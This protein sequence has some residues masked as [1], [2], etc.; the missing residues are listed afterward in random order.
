MGSSEVKVQ[1]GGLKPMY[2]LRRKCQMLLP[3]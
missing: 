3:L 2:V 1:V